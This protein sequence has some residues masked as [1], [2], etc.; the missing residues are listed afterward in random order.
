MDPLQVQDIIANITRQIEDLTYRIYRLEDSV[1]EM[2]AY[3]EE[4]K[5]EVIDA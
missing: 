5:E 3:I 4:N 1:A 2:S